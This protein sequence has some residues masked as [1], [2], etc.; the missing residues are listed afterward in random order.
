[1]IKIPFSI[2]S[3]VIE[4]L[5]KKEFQ[6]HEVKAIEEHIRIIEDVIKWAGWDTEEY[7]NRWYYGESN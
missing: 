5:Y 3:P 6:D 4:D 7:M 2:L 1:M